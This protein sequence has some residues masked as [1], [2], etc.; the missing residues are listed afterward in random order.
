MKN[1]PNG[2]DPVGKVKDPAAEEKRTQI[3]LEISP[4]EDS[5][6]EMKELLQRTQ[7]NFEN[8]RKQN[9]KRIS[10]MEKLAARHIL[11]EIFPIL[12][13]FQLALQNTNHQKHEEFV[14]GIELIY[15]QLSSILEHHEIKVM[16]TIGKQF[17]P[18]YH[19][20]LMKVE[21]D[22]PEGIILEEFQKGYAL[23]GSVLRHARVKI[24]AGKN[25]Q[26][27]IK[28]NTQNTINGGL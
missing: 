10:E 4:K 27:N 9:E 26:D 2:T 16:E 11:C 8:Y 28:T 22:Q 25:K 20:A 3:K 18:Y 24:S 17:N 23:H 13:N 6:E 19:E 7:A 1:K 14:K 12:D 5:L 15:A 21:S